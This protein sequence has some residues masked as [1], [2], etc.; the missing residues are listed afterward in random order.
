[1]IQG[2]SNR[3]VRI[4][5]KLKEDS[6]TS[7]IIGTL[8][9]FPVE[10]FWRTL[11]N[12]CFDK[13][14]PLNSGE[15]ISFNFWPH[16]DSKNTIN[17]KYVEPDVFIEFENF[18]LIIEA[19]RWD[20]NQQYKEQWLSQYQAYKNEYELLE[21]MNECEKKLLYFAIGGIRNK[22]TEFLKDSVSVYKFQWKYILNEILSIK[23]SL[24]SS[25]D[26]LSNSNAIIRIA[27][28]LIV[29]FELHGFFTG[30][31]L[32]TLTYKKVNKIKSLKSINNWKI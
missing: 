24:E 21:P 9:F 26:L 22:K 15:I 6:L 16:W 28:T 14:L 29:A 11:R 8:L 2:L 7:S 5:A 23:K 32:E 31:W 19:K 30:A 17:S 27:E 3:K 25:M 18:N 10:L 4:E 12:S 1:M 13:S 20:E